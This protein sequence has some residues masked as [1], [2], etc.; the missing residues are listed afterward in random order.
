[1]PVRVPQ[2]ELLIGL[3]GAGWAGREHCRSIA[4]IG[5]ARVCALVD[6]DK[7]QARPAADELSATAYPDVETL[8]ATEELDAVVVATPPGSHADPVISALEAGVA[9]FVEKPLARTAEDAQAIVDAAERSRAVCAVGYQWRAM[10]LLAV[11]RAEL[12]EHATALL[13]SQGVG[14]TQARSWFDDPRQSG[15]LVSERASHHIDLQRAIAGEVVA[16]HAARG[17]VGLSGGRR[18]SDVMEDVVSLTLRFASGAIGAIH[19][20]WTP[21]DGPGRQSLDAYA[22]GVSFDVMLDPSFVLD[23]R[24]GA[25]PVRA[26]VDEHPFRRQMRAF[27]DAVRAGDP[28][29]VTCHARDAAGSLAVALAAE[30]AMDLS[31]D[32]AVESIRA[33]EADAS[34]RHGHK[35]W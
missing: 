21:D 13:V 8:L 27:L 20:G 16:V 2:R 25:R 1:M 10:N 4:N 22:T 32:V 28:T 9:A 3:I 14:P 5:G 6:A 17:G 33:P 24:V 7:T 11:L 26:T 18:S 23:G 29:A 12:G 15:R 35:A 19:V 34:P 31:E 30:R